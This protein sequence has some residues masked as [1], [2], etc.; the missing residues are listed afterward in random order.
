MPTLL[1]V[2]VWWRHRRRRRRRAPTTTHQYT[3]HVLR[4]GEAIPRIP[5]YELEPRAFFE[6]FVAARRPV[7]ICGLLP[8]LGQLG[9]DE[10]ER[11]AGDC[12]VDVE[13]RDGERDA[14]GKGRK[15]RMRFGELLEHLRRGSTRYYLTT[16]PLPDE[17]LVAPRSRQYRL[18]W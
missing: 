16:Q 13:V 8:E 11:A 12:D 5:L 6:R 4:R 3:G 18:S 9:D 14:F 17:A 10:L 15:E 1:P 7:I 2:S